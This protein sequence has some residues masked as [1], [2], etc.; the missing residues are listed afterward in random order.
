[1]GVRCPLRQEEVGLPHGPAQR[2]AR[3]ETW[4]NGS[5]EYSGK[6]GV[7]GPFSV[8]TELGY[9]YLISNPQQMTRMV[10]HVRG[11]TCSSDSLACVDIRTGKM[12]WYY[13]L[14]HHDIWTTTCR[15]SILV[16]LNIDGRAGQ[17]RSC[18]CRAG[19]RVRV[20]SSHRPA[21]VRL[22]A[23]RAADRREGEWTSPTQPFRSSCPLSTFKE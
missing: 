18:N 23:F 17:G 15:A 16:D 22:R 10:D 3:L 19:I 8:D 7:W 21:R 4:L 20:R 1:M 13:Q 6:C 14:V 2:R 5:A 11:T 12:I 9:V